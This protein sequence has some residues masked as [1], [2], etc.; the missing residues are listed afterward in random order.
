[1]LHAG[2]KADWQINIAN[3]GADVITASDHISLLGV[4]VSADLSLD[5]RFRRQCS[6]LLLASPASTSSSIT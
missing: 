3:R 1:M 2:F 5:Q 6:E 4:T